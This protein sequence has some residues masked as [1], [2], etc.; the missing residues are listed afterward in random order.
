MS[1][2]LTMR[3]LVETSEFV[4]ELLPPVVGS[5][6]HGNSFS[7]PCISSQLSQCRG[8]VQLME[9]CL[10]GTPLSSIRA[11]NGSRVL[12]PRT[13][14]GGPWFFL[15]ETHVLVF[16][17]ESIFQRVWFLRDPCI[18]TTLSRRDLNTVS[19]TKSSRCLRPFVEPMDIAPDKTIDVRVPARPSSSVS[20]STFQGVA[21]DCGKSPT[22]R[23]SF[24]APGH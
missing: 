8:D 12:F 2:H 1:C 14:M 19:P 10:S 17:R 3:T 22:A 24:G 9:L 6:G 18:K 20:A 16:R 11:D 7:A 5:V 4:E 23:D 13:T 15:P 21:T